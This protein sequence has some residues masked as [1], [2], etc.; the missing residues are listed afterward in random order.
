MNNLEGALHKEHLFWKESAKVKW[1]LEGDRNTKYFHKIYKIKSA[2]NNIYALIIDENL[3]SDQETLS[4]YVVDHFKNLFSFPV[5]INIDLD[6][7]KDI[8]LNLISHEDN[9]L[10]T[11]IHTDIEIKEAIFNLNKDGAHEPDGFRAFF[12]QHY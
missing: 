2:T 5:G 1:H 11:N 8:I 6:L 4:S 3:V 7:I 10:L 9:Q 12:F